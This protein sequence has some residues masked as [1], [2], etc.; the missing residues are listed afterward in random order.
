MLKVENRESAHVKSRVKDLSVVPNVVSY[1]GLF[2]CITPLSKALP[3]DDVYEPILIRDT[4]SLIA[5]FGDPRIDPEKYIDL[6]SIMQVVGNGTSCYVCKVKSGETGVYKVG[7]LGNLETISWDVSGENKI[8]TSTQEFAKPFILASIQATK[9]ESPVVPITIVDGEPAAEGQCKYEF[10]DGVTPGKVKLKITLHTALATGYTLSNVISWPVDA[11]YSMTVYSSLSEDIT[12]EADAIQAKPYSLKAFYLV[13]RVKNGSNT[14]ATAKV[15][16][17]PTTTNQGLVDS[18]NSILNT[19]VNFTLD[20]ESH[21]DACEVKE[22]GEFSIVCALLDKVAPK[23]EGVRANIAGGEVSLAAPQIEIQRPKFT[24]SLSDYE[25]AYNQFKDKRYSGC[26]LSDLT[27]PM[28]HRGYDDDYNPNA[29]D[30]ST[31]VDSLDV[32]TLEERRSLHFYLKQVACERKDATVI[33]SVPYINIEIADKTLGSE[34]G[35]DHFKGTTALTMNEACD[36]VASQNNFSNLW[37]YGSTN[38][39][40]YAE[41]SFYLEIYYS[42]LNMKCTKIENGLAKS[43]TVK[44]APSN[45]VINN[46]LTSFRERGTQYPVAGDQLGTLPDY[47]SVLT[48][49]KTKAERDQLVQYRINP[50]YDTGTRGVQI[51]GNETLNAGYTDLNAAHIAR[52]LVNIRNRV[53]EF[54]ESIKFSINNQILWDTWKNFVSSRILE[55]LKSVNAISSYTVSMGNDTTSAAEIAN[56]RINGIVELTFYQSAEIFSLDF[57]VYSSATAFEE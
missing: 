36:W 10:I 6:Y 38:T 25:K 41:Q 14:L 55:P 50:I 40:D 43:V 45:V 30:P 13:V 24:V 19:Y 35:K 54:T 2:A 44:T 57:V 8:Y 15:K 27:S 23:A 33:L 7:F 53:D 37:E 21:K 3:V 9:A 34:D 51:Y 18:L 5:N 48:N 42:W 26:I 52:T 4:D 17:E 47:C 29:P 11:A 12:I 16:L 56:R 20:D 46:I 32:P 1:T 31:Y 22:N 28:I 49:P 39:T